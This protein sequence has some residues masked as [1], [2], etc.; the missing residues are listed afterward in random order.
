[1]YF[2]HH[3]N[4]HISYPYEFSLFRES[5]EI[6]FS[7]KLFLLREYRHHKSQTFNWILRRPRECEHKRK[8]HRIYTC[9]HLS[10]ILFDVKHVCTCHCRGVATHRAEK[11]K[12][13]DALYIYVHFCFSYKCIAI[14]TT[15]TVCQKNR[16][17]M[18]CNFRNTESYRYAKVRKI[19]VISFQGKMLII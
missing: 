12:R 1:M 6:L 18:P 2:T 19:L 14:L 16:Y 8:F 10:R 5:P 3:N 9:A 11:W 13:R 4:F 15:T 17:K 7:T